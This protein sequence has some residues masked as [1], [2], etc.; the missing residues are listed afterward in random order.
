[1]SNIAAPAMSSSVPTKVFRAMRKDQGGAPLCGSDSNMLGARPG[2]DIRADAEGRV[3]GGQGGLSVTPDDPKLLPPHVRPP[4]FGGKGKLPLF[5]LPTSSL[6]AALSYRADPERP[7]RHGFL[8][9]G[10]E[11]LLA[12][13]QAALAATQSAWKEVA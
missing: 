4:R 10:S 5:E 13:Y 7:T 9:P 1:M 6:T 3:L 11:M 12:E 2:V 8:E